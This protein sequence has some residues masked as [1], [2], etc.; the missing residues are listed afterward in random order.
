MSKADYQSLYPA[1]VAE[2]QRRWEASLAEEKFD[3]AVVHSG[4]PMYSFQDDYEYAFRPNPHFLAWLPLTH[5]H[6]SVLMI[7]PGEKPRLIYFQPDDYWYL[8]P[9]DPEPWWAEQFEIE[10]VRGAD[11]WHRRVPSGR[12]AA[13]GDSANLAEVY[14]RRRVNPSLLTHRLH[15]WRTRKTPYEIACIQQAA[16]LAAVAHVAAEKAFRDGE[17]EYGIHMRYLAACDHTDTELPY[18]NIVALNTHGAVLHYQAR[19]RELPGEVRSFL[20]DGGCAVNGYASDITRTY[21]KEQGEFADMIA[22][23]DVLERDLVGKVRAGLDYKDL[24]LD[25]HRMIAGLLRDFGVLNVSPEDAV[26]SG[27]SWVFYPHGLG[28]FLG[29]QVHDVAGLVD[30]AGNAIPRP[31][32]FPALRLTRVLEEGNVLTIEPGLYFID[33]LLD[34]WRAEKDAAMVNWER[35]EALKPYGGIRIEDDVVVQADGCDDLTRRAF[36]ELG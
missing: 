6:D 19:E 22:A 17:T 2:M 8:P 33:S 15:I 34:K 36:A 13:L 35:V 5:H 30:N 25:S 18:N 32:G 23:M 9:S 31:D 21:A 4:T 12:V 20:I 27:L 16:N 29:L 28:H 7:V 24:F 26:E 10:V 11:E 3:A 1:H 14:G